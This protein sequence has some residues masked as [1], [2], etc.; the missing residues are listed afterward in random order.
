MTTEPTTRLAPTLIA[1]GLGAFAIGVSEFAAMGLLPYY[2]DGFGVSEPA[3]GH[4]I[5][6]Y[7]LGVVIGAPVLAVL[8]ARFPRKA[9]L[10][11]LIAVFGI[12]NLL[13]AIAPSMNLLTTTRVL[14][15]LPHGAYLGIAM[16][17]AA[18]LLPKGQR[19]K[20]VARV[21]LGLTLANVIGV[22]LASAIGQS[23][24]WRS[25]FVI[26]AVLAAASAT[27][28]LRVAPDPAPAE[29]ASP[30]RELAA[31]KN[32]AVWLTLA[33]GAVGFGGVFAAYSYFSAAMIESASAPAWAIPLGLSA[34]GVG[35]TFGNE[36]AGRLASW[37]RM[38]GTLVLLS[39]MVATTL[40]YAAVMGNWPLMVLSILLLGSTAGLV[41]PLQMRLMDVAGEAQTLAAAL[42]HAAFNFA[43]ALGPFAAGLALS[44][45]MGWSATG[46]VGATLSALGIVVLAIA[47]TDGKRQGGLAVPAE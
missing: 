15:G 45:G 32:R 36:I 43:N 24:G 13:G 6:G 22:P 42:N 3:A 40:L 16:L 26:V 30:M 33:V 39:G 21:L 18:D 34:F 23:I 12:A 20:G 11:S 1:L 2:A 27:M 14:S 5:S 46:L 37:S 35:A 19:A 47:W 10:A 29:G 44:A 4:A 25:L 31:L 9:V 41:V 28:I 17:F 7:A 38:G 8:L